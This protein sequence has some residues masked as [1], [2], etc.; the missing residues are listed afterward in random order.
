[1]RLED[2]TLRCV[3]C[4]AEFTFSVQD[5]E[6]HRSRGYTNEPKR[7]TGCRETRRAGRSSSGGGSSARREMYPAVCAQ[8]GTQ[9]QVPFQPRGDRP[10]YCSDCYNRVRPDSSRR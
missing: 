4:G 7:C 5:Q 10:V 9:T 6:F 8:C 1:M 2:K 3:D